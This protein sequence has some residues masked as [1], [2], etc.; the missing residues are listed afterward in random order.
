[1]PGDGSQQY[2]LLPCSQLT[3]EQKTFIFIHN[4]DVMLISEM[5]FIEKSYLKLHKYTAYHTNHS[6]GT[7]QGGAVIKLQQA[8]STNQ[9]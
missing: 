2:R 1:L 8:S 4:F 5:H 9:L 3:A 6:A 7:D